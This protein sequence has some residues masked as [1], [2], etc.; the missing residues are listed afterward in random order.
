MKEN[1]IKDIESL[2]PADSDY[3]DT[4]AIGEELLQLAMQRAGFNW[5]QLPIQVLQ[6]YRSLC[7]SKENDQIREAEV[8]RHSL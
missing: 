3:P 7:I 5:R 2:F 8:K 1:I 4:A 6:E